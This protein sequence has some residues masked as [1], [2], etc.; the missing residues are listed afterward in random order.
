[1]SQEAGIEALAS[2]SNPT[3][4][5]AQIARTQLVFQSLTYKIE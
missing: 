4:H 5:L 1:M 3:Y 2:S